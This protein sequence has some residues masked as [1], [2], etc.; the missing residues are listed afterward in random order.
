[1]VACLREEDA[2]D[3]DFGGL[4]SSVSEGYLPGFSPVIDGDFI[5]KAPRFT[6]EAGESRRIFSLVII[7]II[8]N[9]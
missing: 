4:M 6:Y 1:M 2:E 8:S 5:P 3:L 9:N 7:V